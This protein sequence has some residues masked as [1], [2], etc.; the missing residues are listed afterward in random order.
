LIPSILLT[1]KQIILELVICITIIVVAFTL[2]YRHVV[3]ASV[4]TLVPSNARSSCASAPQLYVLP[5]QNVEVNCPYAMNFINYRSADTLKFMTKGN[6]HARWSSC[7]REAYNTESIAL[8][9]QTVS[10]IT[11]IVIPLQVST[12]IYGEY[13]ATAVSDDNCFSLTCGFNYA[14][15][16]QDAKIKDVLNNSLYVLVPYTD[17]DVYS[18][19]NGDIYLDNGQI[20][21]SVYV[22]NNSVVATCTIGVVGTIQVVLTQSNSIAGSGTYLCTTYTNTLQAISSALSVTLTTIGLVRVYFLTKQYF[23]EMNQKEN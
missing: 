13:S 2:S 4:E 3:N 20:F 5:E 22:T 9:A 18:K 21:T 16:I 19:A 10:N 14:P 12:L 11:S 6:F 7:R 17:E 15:T 1:K 23:S 8:Q